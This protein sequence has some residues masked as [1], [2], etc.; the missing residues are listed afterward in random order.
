MNENLCK[1]TKKNFEK[2]LDI[3][4]IIVYNKDTVKGEFRCN[5]W[6][7]TCYHVP[8]WVEKPT[9]ETISLNKILT[10]SSQ[11]VHWQ[12]TQNDV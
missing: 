7:V 9:V 5:E 1:M 11:N 10:K 3:F 2:R 6:T 8:K 12:K 4:L